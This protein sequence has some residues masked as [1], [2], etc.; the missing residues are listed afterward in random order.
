[1]WA[2]IVWL[3]NNGFQNRFCF[4]LKLRRE[5]MQKK[6]NVIW[7]CD[8]L[9]VLYSI[10]VSCTCIQHH[11]TSDTKDKIAKRNFLPLS[12]ALKCTLPNALHIFIFFGFVSHFKAIAI[13]GRRDRKISFWKSQRYG[14]YSVLQINTSYSFWKFFSAICSPTIEMGRERERDWNW[15]SQ[16]ANEREIACVW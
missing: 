10:L 13:Q 12:V 11:V 5:N 6:I 14:I 3:G 7:I 2:R 1:M 15:A 8:S 4:H 9:C 16:I